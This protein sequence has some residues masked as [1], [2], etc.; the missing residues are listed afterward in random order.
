MGVEQRATYQ[1]FPVV[2][3]NDWY[4]SMDPAKF[5][6]R[7]A[8]VGLQHVVKGDEWVVNDA[9]KTWKQKKVDRYF[10]RYLDRLP[11]GMDYPS[12]IMR[13]GGLLKREPLNR[14]TFVLDRTGIGAPIADAFQRAGLK[15]LNIVITGRREIGRMDTSTFTVPKQHLCAL[16]ESTISFGELKIA[17]E[18]SEANNLIEEMIGFSWRERE[19]GYVQYSAKSGK[20][21]DYCL[22]VTYALFAAT[23]RSVTVQEPLPFG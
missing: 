2:E 18:L 6:D 14:A 8:L 3:R 5:Q 15:P 1:K 9:A 16:L 12:Q 21:D 11:K 20:F 19:S 23:N 17:P 7:S 4:L 10:V 22:A 13:V